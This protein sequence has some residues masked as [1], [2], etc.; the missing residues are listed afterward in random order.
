MLFRSWEFVLHVYFSY[1]V[2]LILHFGN[3]IE[4]DLDISSEEKASQLVSSIFYS[5]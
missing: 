3:S 2:N 4:K 1:S 5:P